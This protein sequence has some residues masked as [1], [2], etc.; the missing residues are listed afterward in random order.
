MREN[1][2]KENSAARQRDYI[3][4]WFEARR[5]FG[6]SDAMRVA[7][8]DLATAQTHWK[9]FPHSKMDGLGGMATTM[10]SAG[11]PSRNLPQSTE[12]AVPSF[13]RFLGLM[14]KQPKPIA[15][16]TIKWKYP[17][18][19]DSSV[20][21][22]IAYDF[23]TEEETAIVKKLAR[24][25]R[26]TFSHY[27][28]WALN[29]AVAEL[30]I[31]GEQHYYWLYP[32]NLRGPLDFNTDMFNYS[33]SINLCVTNR[34]EPRKLQERVKEQLKAKAYWVNWYLGNIGKL[35]GKSGVKWVYQYISKRQFYA[36]SFSFLGSWPL[37]DAENPKKNL[38]EMWVACGIGTR[39]YPVS[40]GIL[41]WYDRLS[42]G[43]KLH[44]SI[45]DDIALTRR[46]LAQWK[47]Y[48]LP[49]SSA[50]RKVVQISPT[51]REKALDTQ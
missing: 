43:I 26:V 11:Y 40:T 32:V 9:T 12:T 45:C 31:D 35:I 51:D 48:L 7:R 29:R 4:M 36:G 50:G 46:C 30:L 24:K 1:I 19:I 17:R 44:P 20:D 21:G 22:E 28:L 39:N 3:A 42:L 33:S 6:I 8:L 10:R 2:D 15:K 13:W 16:K 23:L 49:E 25:N 14:F 5:E 34:I 41:V 47:R 18:D 37:P 38:N 27:I